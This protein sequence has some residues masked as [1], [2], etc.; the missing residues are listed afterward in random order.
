MIELLI[1]TIYFVLKIHVH[2]SSVGTHMSSTLRDKAEQLLCYFMPV[3]LYQKVG[4]KNTYVAINQT[5]TCFTHRGTSSGH[6]L[7]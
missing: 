3:L 4:A 6:R 1:F 7:F 5:K 2:P